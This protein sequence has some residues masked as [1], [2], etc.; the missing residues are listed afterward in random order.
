MKSKG[1]HEGQRGAVGKHCLFHYNVNLKHQFLVS[2]AN[3][4]WTLDY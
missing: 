1:Q 2:T 3:V 4:T